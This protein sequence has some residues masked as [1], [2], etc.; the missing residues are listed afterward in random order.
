MHWTRAAGR[1]A[2]PVKLSRCAFR[3]AAV[4]AWPVTSHIAA[5]GPWN[6]P[7]VPKPQ[8][9]HRCHTRVV[10]ASTCKRDAFFRTMAPRERVLRRVRVGTNTPP[11]CRMGEARPHAR[12]CGARWAH[13]AAAT[14]SGAIRSHVGE[15]VKSC[16]RSKTN[17]QGFSRTTAVEG[18]NKNDWSSCLGKT[19]LAQL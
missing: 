9:A 12:R 3:K 18:V 8:S 5:W 2:R 19:S 4:T 7:T 1:D 14:R 15:G 11:H 17:V 13:V 6:R 10:R 16:C